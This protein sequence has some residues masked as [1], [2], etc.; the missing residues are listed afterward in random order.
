MAGATGFFPEAVAWPLIATDSFREALPKAANDTAGA[1]AGGLA[2]LYYGYN[3]IPPEWV[4]EMKRMSPGE[5][6][7]SRTPGKKETRIPLKYREP[8]F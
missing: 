3:A 7:E 5:K 6:P 8:G 1:A 2:A 4:A